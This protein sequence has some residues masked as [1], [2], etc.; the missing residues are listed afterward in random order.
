MTP[1]ERLEEWLLRVTVP[2][3]YKQVLEEYFSALGDWSRVDAL[4]ETDLDDMGIFVVPHRIALLGTTAA[5]DPTCTPGG[6]DGDVA[7]AASGV[8]SLNTSGIFLAGGDT[9]FEAGSLSAGLE[10]GASFSVSRT[11]AS[12][13]TRRSRASFASSSASDIRR[14]GDSVRAVVC[15]VC[16]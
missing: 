5:V 8:G 3:Y 11:S 14:R 12:S 1:Q 16:S 13:T 2:E 10:S 6:M 4:S 7:Q 9:S 15:F